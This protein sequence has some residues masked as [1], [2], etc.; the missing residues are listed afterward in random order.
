MKW[1]TSHVFDRTQ[2]HCELSQQSCELC[3]KSN[4]AAKQLYIFH[5][6]RMHSDVGNYKDTCESTKML[7]CVQDPSA[8][9]HIPWAVSNNKARTVSKQTQWANTGAVF[10][11]WMR[12]AFRARSKR[13][14][15][16]QSVSTCVLYLQPLLY[17]QAKQQM[18]VALSI[19]QT[20]Q[21]ILFWAG[22]KQVSF[23]W[24]DSEKDCRGPLLSCA[25][26]NMEN[27]VSIH[28]RDVLFAL[29]CD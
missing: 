15:E 28:K 16:Y 25:S 7:C 13:I 5:I 14:T 27:F 21:R 8:A 29:K 12:G 24:F 20:G 22:E 1:E 11:R 6:W 3:E 9:K 2:D 17:K 26:S 18:R 4:T 10:I 19:K 23:V